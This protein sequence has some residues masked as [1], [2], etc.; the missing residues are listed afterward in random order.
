MRRRDYLESISVDR[1]LWPTLFQVGSLSAICLA[2]Y[3]QVMVSEH[4]PYVKPDFYS[5]FT[6]ASAKG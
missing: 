6:A 1:H 4:V 2:L 5:I 3:R